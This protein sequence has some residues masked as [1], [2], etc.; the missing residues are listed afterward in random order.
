MI[1]S[2]TVDNYFIF[3][4]EQTFEFATNSERCVPICSLIGANGSGKTMTIRA[5]SFITNLLARRVKHQTNHQ[6]EILKPHFSRTDEPSH[7]KLEFIVEGVQYR[8]EISAYPRFI[9]REAL[10]VRNSRQFSY[11]FIREADT[12]DNITS[13]K[14]KK[15]TLPREFAEAAPTNQS[16]LAYVPNNNYPVIKAIQTYF[17]NSINTFMDYSVVD[18]L[19]EKPELTEPLSNIIASLDFGIDGIRL[20]EDGYQSK[21]V[22]CL[23]K[24]GNDDIWFDLKSE[25]SGTQLV[26][27]LML[28]MIDTLKAGSPLIIDHFDNNV[29]PILT[30]HLIQLFRD[31]NTN[32]NG[33]Q[34]ICSTQRADHLN[35]LTRPEVYFIEQGSPYRADEIKGL[36]KTDNLQQKYMAGA[37]GA[38]PNIS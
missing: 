6:F 33:A 35:K 30:E 20:E 27:E 19:T 4:E 37:L 2:L 17:K 13:Y 21:K 11:V 9:A 7:L 24:T 32:N 10:Y 3:G 29:H 16:M 36:R 8:Y 26:L 23:H 18:T 34:L 5:L 12:P 28:K 31:K 38:T 15:F 1:T 25:S 14:A 22:T